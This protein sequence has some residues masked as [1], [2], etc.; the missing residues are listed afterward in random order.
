MAE[1]SG[2]TFG[3]CKDDIATVVAN[4]VCGDDVRVLKRTNAGTKLLLD[5]C[6]AIVGAFATYDVTATGTI[7]LLPKELENAIEVEVL[8]DA[9]VRGQR[10]V[11]EG[12]YNLVNN[13]VFL[14][15]A[16]AHDNPLEDLFLERDPVTHTVLRRKYNYPGLQANAVV[17][18]TGR[19]RYIPLTGD[20]D[21][22]L[23]QNVEA[24]KSAILYLEYKDRGPGSIADAK[25]YLAD[26]KEMIEA[27]AKQ[28]QIDPRRAMARKADFQ[29]DI[30]TY[31]EGTLGRTRGRLALE[32]PGFLLKGKAEITYLI[33]RAVQMLVDNRNQ[34]AIAGRIS[35]HGTTT[36]LA[37]TPT[38]SAGTTLPWSDY[39]QIRLMV[40]SF[41]T[42]SPDPQSV[43]VSEEY[44]KQAFELQKAQLV[45]A[46]EKARHTTYTTALSEYVFGTFGWMV[47]RLALE[48]PGG[49]AMTTTEIERL[50]SMAEMRILER[51][52]YKG[53][54]KTLT[55]TI[56][57]G[58]I[59]FPRDVEAVL[60]AD[61]CGQPIDIRSCYFEY[62]KNGPGHSFDCE[63]RFVDLGEVFFPQT[64]TRRRKYAYRGSTSAVELT[65]V[66]KVRFVQKSACD[67]MVI[68]NFPAIQLFAEGIKSDNVQK[69]SE[70]IDV[71][72][73]EMS[74]HLSGIAHT[75]NVDCSFYGFEGVGSPL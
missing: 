39:N 14:D 23:V 68:K 44:K 32:L 20:N 7:L 60:A 16:A 35:V 75:A 73:H 15:P 56:T 46:T 40:Q 29:S 13:S 67:E 1:I 57:G 59:L 27:E 72:E 5:M 45:E 4:G 64:G 3:L 42:E 61:I 36:E 37:Y 34:L 63:G 17:R 24:L 66:C 25:M 47:A 49:L 43:A 12:G 69:M 41:V 55:A 6:P 21:S 22:L 9:T 58:D 51:G 52:I 74:E 70:A 31:G 26:A 2:T 71:L 33:N 53:S 62:Q 48:M 19:K 30:T 38:N 10:D 65:A 11:T 18:V 54:L 50:V 28:H 8:N